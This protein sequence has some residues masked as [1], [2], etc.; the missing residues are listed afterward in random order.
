MKAKRRPAPQRKSYHHGDLPQALRDAAKQLLAE[1][2]PEA[3]SLR[4]AARLVGVNHRAVYR[5]YEDKRALFAALAEEGF[6][7]LTQR[8]RAALDKLPE[9]DTAERLLA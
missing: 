1:G 4:E 3:L 9:D 5:H 6:Q 8:L 7:Q 2:G